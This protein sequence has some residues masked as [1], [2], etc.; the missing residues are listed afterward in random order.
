M[1][2][3]WWPWAVLVAVLVVL[4]TLFFVV[5]AL[6]RLRSLRGFVHE[7]N[8]PATA[9][10]AYYGAWIYA[11]SPIDLLPDPILLDDVG[12]V[13]AAIATLEYMVRKRRPDGLIQR[14]EGP[15][16]LP[17]PDTARPR[18]KR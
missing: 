7:R 2:D 8:S 9:K 16:P 10:A 3:G 1:P 15:G 17:L 6:I 13:L 5:R 14:P 12:I 11:L 18:G 4:G